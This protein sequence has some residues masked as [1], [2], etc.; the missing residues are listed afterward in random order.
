MLGAPAKPPGVIFLGS[1]VGDEFLE[2]WVLCFHGSLTLLSQSFG[3]P[4]ALIAGFLILDYQRPLCMC[5]HLSA[6]S[7]SLPLQ[8]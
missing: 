2:S 6:F 4:K 1:P 5:A 3:K 8:L 7:M